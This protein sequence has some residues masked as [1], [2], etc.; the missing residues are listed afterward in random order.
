MSLPGLQ[1]NSVPVEVKTSSI[2]ELSRGTEWRFEVAFGENVDVKLL[3]G[4]AEIF[5]TELALNQPYN[6]DG[7]KAAV[8]TWHGCRLE[9]T[10]KCHIDYTAEETPMTSYVNTH[11][12]LENLRN[13]ALEEDSIGPRVLVVGP[14]NA[15]KTTLVKL[16]AAYAT[17]SERQPVV[18]NL[19]PKEGLLS[20]P[21]TLS[22]IVLD[23][24]IDV[25]QGWGSSPMNGPSHVPVKLPLVYYYG[26]ED[27]E[28]QGEL[29]KPI[30]TRLAL[31]VMSRLE[32]DKEA[33]H[34]GCI[35]DTSGSISSGKAAYD[36]IRHIV[37]EFSVNVLI[38]LGS[39]RLY[40]DMSRRFAKQTSSTRD[41]VS[42]IKLD[43]SGGCVDRDSDYLQQFRQAQIRE[44]FF[45]DARNPLS[46]H[47]QQID[48]SDL[49]IYRVAEQSSMLHSLLPGGEAED[50]GNQDI[51]DRVEPS[52]DMQSCILAIVQADPNDTLD[53]IRDSSVIGF[54]YVA[55]VDEKKRKMRVLAPISGRV[56]RKAMIW[57][58]WPESAGDLVG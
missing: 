47:T 29:Y 30:V 5:G 14:E 33:K 32:E 38:V 3:S 16:L 28:A 48:F 2:H 22:T 24:V 12:A 57:G 8:Y 27:P 49:S 10:G 1:L 43:K 13:A 26:I 56:P 20:V 50:P 34:S 46:P 45:G 37:A 39:E 15:G 36:I 21:G 25:E 55:E 35:I 42:V 44:Y 7:R 9:A 11:F 17:R 40:S 19:D 18:V 41:S 53:S 6:F 58:Q 31:S 51:F 4:T 52:A 23:S 54:V